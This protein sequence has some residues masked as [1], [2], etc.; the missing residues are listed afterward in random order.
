MFEKVEGEHHARTV[1]YCLPT[2]HREAHMMNKHQHSKL[3]VVV[4]CCSLFC[5]AWGSVAQKTTETRHPYVSDKPILEP[6]IF[7]EGTISTGDYDSHPAFTSDGRTLYFLKSTP[8]FNFWTIVVSRFENGKWNAPEVAPFSGQWSDADPFI[9]EDGAKL[10]FISTRPQEGQ[11]NRNLDIWVVEKT[12][13]GWGKPRNLGVPINSSGRE[14]YPTLAR[15]GTLYFGSDREGGKGATDIYRSRLVDGKYGVPENL[16]DAIN[17]PAG[18]FEPFIAPDESYLIFAAVGRPD[19][20]GGF[21][22]YISYNRNGAWTKAVNLGNKINSS[23]TDFSPKISP[24][25]KYF[26]WTSTRGFADQPLT[27]RLNGQ[28][29]LVKLRSANNGLGDI[30]QIELSALK[31]ER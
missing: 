31:I 12:A 1:I 3:R 19:G 25:G 16:G 9:T 17:T 8:N 11:S 20:L 28:D 26:F 14:W 4:L 24:D 30:Y 22:L 13:D 10:Y 27:T 6:T 29:L 5:F 15:N 21:D 2:P 23:G 7:G 18:E